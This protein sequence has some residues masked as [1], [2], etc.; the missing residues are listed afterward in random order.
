MAEPRPNRGGRPPVAIEQQRTHAVC[1]RFT[2]AEAR[3]L[4]RRAAAR[5]CAVAALVRE[6]LARVPDADAGSAPAPSASDERMALRRQVQ[7]VGRLL[8]DAVHALHRDRGTPDHETL[9]A[10]RRAADA[11][12]RELGRWP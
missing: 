10:L 8:N 12:A 7:R 5:G 6:D 1:V 3:V 9:A 4:R 11:V 2:A